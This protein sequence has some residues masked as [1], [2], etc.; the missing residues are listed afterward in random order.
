MDKGVENALSGLIANINAENLEAVIRAVN[1]AQSAAWNKGL[2][3]GIGFA[4]RLQNDHDTWEP[5]DPY[6]KDK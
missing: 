3:S 4:V 2:V 1:I 5:T 6:R